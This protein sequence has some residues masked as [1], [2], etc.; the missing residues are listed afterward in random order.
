MRAF[1]WLMF[2][3][4]WLLG[5]GCVTSAPP[6]APKPGKAAAVAQRDSYDEGNGLVE[7]ASPVADVSSASQAAAPVAAASSTTAGSKGADGSDGSTKTAGASPRAAAA[8]AS[9]GAA[10]PGGSASSGSASSGGGS[11][12][13]GS[14]GGGSSG[15]AGSVQSIAVVPTVLTTIPGVNAGG[16]SGNGKAAIERPAGNGD[17][18]VARRL[19]KAAEQET[20]PELRRKL[21]QEYVN[22]RKNAQTP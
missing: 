5:S 19:R 3:T 16:G 11:S 8:A 9:G 14:S 10:A 13:G 22:Y 7:F 15:G 20:D 12:G 18:I 4:A 1:S 17:D 21:W 2:A 6:Q